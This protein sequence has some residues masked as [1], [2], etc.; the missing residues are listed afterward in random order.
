MSLL[1]WN[2]SDCLSQ[3]LEALQAESNRLRH[4]GNE[5]A[6]VVIDNG[7]TDSTQRVLDQCAAAD[8]QFFRL[9]NAVNIGAAKAR[10]Q[11]FDFALLYNSD[12]HF[13]LDGDISVVPGSICAELNYLERHP[14]LCSVGPYYES[15]TPDPAAA[16]PYFE[17]I[18]Q[19]FPEICA[20]TQYGLFRRSVFE[21][22]RFDEYFGAGWAFE[23]V[24]FGLMLLVN[25]FRSRMFLG[26]RYLHY[27]YHSSVRLLRESGTDMARMWTDRKQYTLT[28]W[29]ARAKECSEVATMWRALRDWDLPSYLL[30]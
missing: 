16:D 1:T 17:R 18:E 20:N 5:T 23:D 2:R 3:C 26:M 12:F 14:E 28:K 10:N 21:R 4:K 27:E 6:I 30:R 15:Q 9:R 24:D 22:F 25:G 19:D 11:A 8:G 29:E 13:L 7:S